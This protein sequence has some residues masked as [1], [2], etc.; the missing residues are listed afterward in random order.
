[1]KRNTI[2]S[3]IALSSLLILTPALARETE[4]GRHGRHTNQTTV[5]KVVRNASVSAS[6]EAEPRDD[7]G[8][9]KEV[10]DDRGRGGHQ[11]LGDDHGNHGG[12]HR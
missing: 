7:R 1:M 9:H 2:S 3:I 10:G 11:E 12:G 8:N 4:S 6:R 5:Q